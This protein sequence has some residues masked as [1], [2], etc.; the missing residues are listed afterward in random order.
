MPHIIILSKGP[1]P[2]ESI[3]L[4]NFN[5]EYYEKDT[6]IFTNIGH[7]YPFVDVMLGCA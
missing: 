6:H 4:S 2:L 5:D 3:S 1:Y 7:G